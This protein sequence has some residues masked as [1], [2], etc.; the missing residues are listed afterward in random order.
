MKFLLNSLSNVNG[1]SH[2]MVLF[3][4]NLIHLSLF[5]WIVI[6]GMESVLE[7]NCFYIIGNF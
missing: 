2:S 6:G 1:V 4:F 7:M 5:W 3:D